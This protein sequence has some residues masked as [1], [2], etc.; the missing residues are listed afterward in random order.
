MSIMMQDPEE[1]TLEQMKALVDSNQAV[2]FTI[3]GREAL[4]GL[5]A[6]VLKNQRYAER[7]RDERGIVKRFLAKV[8]GRVAIEAVVPPSLRK[9]KFRPPD[10]LL[11]ILKGKP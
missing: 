7:S 8:T 2:R 3:E 1:M 11:A 9:G 4:Y 5:I 6:Q 10:K